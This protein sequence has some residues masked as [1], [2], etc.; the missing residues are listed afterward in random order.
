[1][2]AD[3]TGSIRA[4]RTEDR[5]GL[6]ACILEL[7][8][9]ERALEPDRVDGARDHVNCKRMCRDRQNLSFVIRPLKGASG[10]CWWIRSASHFPTMSRRRTCTIPKER[11][12]SL[13]D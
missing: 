4:Y 10:I 2:K 1:V 6:A 8:D 13:V 11:E 7:Q 3:V 9:F 5:A 12:D